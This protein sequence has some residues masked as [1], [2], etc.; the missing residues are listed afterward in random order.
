MHRA[1]GGRWSAV[2]WARQNKLKDG[3]H[4][5][6]FR[7]TPALCPTL[8]ASR[9]PLLGPSPPSLGVCRDQG[10]LL[11]ALPPTPAPYP[12]GGAQA[13]TC[14]TPVLE[15]ACGPVPPPPFCPEGV[16]GHAGPGWLK[17]PTTQSFRS[18]GNFVHPVDPFRAPSP[19]LRVPSL[20]PSHHQP[21]RQGPCGV[22]TLSFHINNLFGRT[23][24]DSRTRWPGRYW[25]AVD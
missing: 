13:R 11:P 17:G 24:Q 16:S 3:A 7:R 9:L 19:W 21:G 14:L 10:P 6:A 4:K 1:G 20:C 5:G 8:S 12:A 15:S 23:W 25:L 22:P 2:D 18:L